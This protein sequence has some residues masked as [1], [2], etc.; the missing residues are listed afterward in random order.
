[1]FGGGVHLHGRNIYP[2]VGAAHADSDGPVEGTT[3]GGLPGGAVPL[4]LGTPGNGKTLLGQPF[5]RAV[6]LRS[7]PYQHVTALGGAEEGTIRNF[8]IGAVACA[9]ARPVTP[10]MEGG[11]APTP[12]AR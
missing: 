9:I 5:L 11:D 6:E 4:V 3:G 12:A 2:R 8:A 1:M 7:R 10:Q